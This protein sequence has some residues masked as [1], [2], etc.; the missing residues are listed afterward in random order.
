MQELGTSYH[1]TI[2][3]SVPFALA[4]SMITPSVLVLCQEGISL[5]VFDVL[6]PGDLKLTRQRQ[7]QCAEYLPS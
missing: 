6:I 5:M 4:G 3:R 7:R 1:A 2:P